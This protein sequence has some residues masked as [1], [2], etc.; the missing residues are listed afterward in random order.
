MKKV[1]WTVCWNNKRFKHMKVSSLMMKTM[2]CIWQTKNKLVS[3]LWVSRVLG[4]NIL[5]YS[6]REELE[7]AQ[8]LIVLPVSLSL[9]VSVVWTVHLVFRWCLC[10][11]LWLREDEPS[12]APSTN[13]APN[14]SNSS[15]RWSVSQTQHFYPVSQ[16]EDASFTRERHEF[17][18]HC[19]S[20]VY[21]TR[22]IHHSFFYTRQQLNQ[23]SYQTFFWTINV[24]KTS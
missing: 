21:F 7:Q 6:F 19:S 12:S 13:P 16:K 5:I 11:K 15:T 23:P 17:R 14:C 10:W 18:F 2:F 24:C 22:F 9:C 4:L 3:G 20:A 8:T 1:C